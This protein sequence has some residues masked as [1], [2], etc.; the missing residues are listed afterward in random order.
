MS[1]EIIASLGAL[2]ATSP[3]E[4]RKE[5]YG[6]LAKPGVKQVGKAIDGIL[7]FGNTIL[8]PVHLLNG[9][10]RIKLENMFDRYRAK[11]EN[12]PQEKIVKVVPEIG[13]PI[14]EKFTY[15]SDDI[16]SEMFLELL[17]KASNIDRVDSVHPGFVKIIERMSPEDALFLKK[18]SDVD[19]IK[20]I[21]MQRDL[22]DA[23]S[24][25]LVTRKEKQTAFE[26]RDYVITNL[27]MQGIIETDSMWGIS[28]TDEDLEI[29]AKFMIDSNHDAI[30]N[31]TCST[32][33]ITEFGR[34]FIKACLKD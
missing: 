31:R 29:I 6:D 9:V 16:L 22:D 1:A 2:I 11:L 28:V 13:V 32:P 21:H 19:F 23:Y 20:R 30:G 34:M 24:V 3:P 8:F 10:V 18:I 33:K 5:I 4:L 7:G 12:I 25:L 26:V 14:I 17:A 15:L 27:Q